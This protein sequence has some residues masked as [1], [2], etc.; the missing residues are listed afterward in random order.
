MN[1]PY[2]DTNELSDENLLLLYSNGDRDAAQILTQRFVP[3]LLSFCTR[4]L[5]DVAGAEDVVQE[6]MIRLWKLGE[7]WQTGEARLSTW[8]FTVA[9]N[10]C[11]D[12]LRKKRPVDID[13]IPEPADDAASNDV[14]LHLAERQSALQVALDQLPERQRTAVILRHIEGL[15]N[16]EIG[17]ILEL[18]VEAV[19]SLTARGKRALASI[20]SSRKEELGL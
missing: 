13:A 2:D 3:R 17:E 7:N 15:S 10:L 19:E 9:R 14:R 20:L 8:V 16:P 6:T 4:M 1:M 12:Q 5:N 11:T 18:S